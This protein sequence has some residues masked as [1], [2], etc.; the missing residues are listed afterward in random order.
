MTLTVPNRTTRLDDSPERLARFLAETGRTGSGVTTVPLAGDASDR[1]YVRVSRPNAPSEILAV[2]PGPIEIATLSFAVVAKLLD[3]MPVPAPRVIAHSDS[4]GIVVLED[5]GD[6]TLQTHLDH[7]SSAERRARYR[8]AIA[9]IHTVQARG[10]ELESAEQLPFSLAFDADKLMWELQFFATH[11][12]VAHREAVLSPAARALLDAEFEAVAG[13]LA[14][15]PRVLCHRDYHSRNL[16]LS[17]GRLYLIDFQDAR[18]GP[19]TYDLVSLLRDSYVDISPTEV[20][21]G[22]EAF[23]SLHSPAGGTDAQR[24][25]RR[26]DLMAVQRNLKALG[27]FGFQATT[28]QKTAYLQYVPRTLGYLKAPLATY[29][30]FNRLRDLLAN[31]LVELR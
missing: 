14:A 15:E 18:M 17:G 25:R 30:R 7:A 20:D 8:E 11:F 2:Y 6:S 31:N 9:L 12:L 5:L 1:R 13:E 10:L 28:H 3:A 19:D 22:I 24:F 29:P 16:M 21:E 23:L 27:T 4:L 26:F